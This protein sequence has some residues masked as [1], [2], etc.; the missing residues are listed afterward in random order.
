M[1]DSCCDHT[2]L[3]CIMQ[4]VTHSSPCGER[5]SSHP[6][7]LWHAQLCHAIE[8]RAFHLRFSTLRVE[9]PRPEPPTEQAL[10]S[11]HCILGDA[12]ACA[13]TD[14][15]P[16]VASLL[17]DLLEDAIA[18]GAPAGG[19]RDGSW[20]RRAPRHEGWCCAAL[21]HRLIAGS[22]VVGPISRHPPHSD[23]E[24]ASGA[25]IPLGCH[26]PDSR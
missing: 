1:C 20:L 3:C 15:P 9:A 12:L 24:F 13:S 7:G 25:R 4:N 11:K 19:L 22:G 8:H 14:D 21:Q 18:R 2:G 10:E 26:G 16:R 17:L 23:Q 5:W 6:H